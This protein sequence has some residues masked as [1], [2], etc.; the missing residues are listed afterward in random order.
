MHGETVDLAYRIS[1]DALPVDNA[2]ALA[3]DVGRV[4][5]W[6]LDDPGSALHTIHGPAS[7]NGWVRP[8]GRRGELLRLSRRTRLVLRLPRSR[9]PAAE[10]LQ[11]ATLEVEGYRLVV[12]DGRVL[13]LRP[14]DSLYARHVVSSEQDD[15]G[16]FLAQARHGLAALGVSGIELLPGLARSVRLERGAHATRSL[17]VTGLGRAASL[18]LQ[19]AGLGPGR[20]LGC[21]VFV[22]H[23]SVMPMSQR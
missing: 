13:A 22:P 20:C 11:G 10:R 15:E 16:E 12:G 5:P 23:K 1:G 3:R 4:L 18:R 8:D 14:A 19:A 21:G 17:L 2:Y 6:F 9:V 7:G